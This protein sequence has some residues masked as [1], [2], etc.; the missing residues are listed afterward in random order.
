MKTSFIISLSVLLSISA[1]LNSCNRYEEGAN[2]SLLSAKQRITEDWTL[3][4]V[5]IN[6][7]DVTYNPYTMTVE[8]NGRYNYTEIPPSG[9]P[10]NDNGFWEFNQSK[11]EVSFIDS[12]GDITTH[13]IM[14]LRNKRL[15]L[16]QK[17]DVDEIVRTF[18][19][20]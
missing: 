5:K 18:E 14:E 3:T 16:K 19:A 15:T 6:G 10:W 2:F 4:N 9:I 12:D 13:T 11:T 7:N 1:L 17:V 20:L 8:K